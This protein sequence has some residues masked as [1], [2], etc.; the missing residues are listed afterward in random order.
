LPAASQLPVSEKTTG[1]AAPVKLLWK[2]EEG[3]G[4][5]PVPI[6][7]IGLHLTGLSITTNNPTFI[8]VTI[9]HSES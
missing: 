6:P 4:N 2:E 1:R 8:K 5:D 9:V 3:K 7:P